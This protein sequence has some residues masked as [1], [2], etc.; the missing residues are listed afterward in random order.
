MPSYTVLLEDPAQAGRVRCIEFSAP[1]ARYAVEIARR[2][3]LP[4]RSELWTEGRFV[5]S[6]RSVRPER[7]WM[8]VSDELVQDAVNGNLAV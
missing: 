4:E 6:L 1:S 8:L 2:L 7:A 3:T 5:C